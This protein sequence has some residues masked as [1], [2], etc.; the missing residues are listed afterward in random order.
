VA[1]EILW[2]KGDENYPRQVLLNAEKHLSAI[3]ESITQAEQKAGVLLTVTIA[4]EAAL[5]AFLG[6]MYSLQNSGAEVF[7]P[8]GVVAVVWWFSIWH[9]YISIEPRR[10]HLVGN[11]PSNWYESIRLGD[12]FWDVVGWEAENYETRINENL[13]TLLSVSAKIKRGARIAMIA[14]LLGILAWLVVWVSSYWVW[15]VWALGF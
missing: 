4:G 10:V 8:V 6:A 3:V 2:A 9:F 14:P 7:V 13:N 5:L 1:D 15:V 12:A 11:I